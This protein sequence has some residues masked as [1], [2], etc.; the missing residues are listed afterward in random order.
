[1]G[2]SGDVAIALT[3]AGP[4]P[5]T[6]VDSSMQVSVTGV[7]IERPAW[8]VLQESTAASGQMVV[9]AFQSDPGVSTFNVK[10]TGLQT[11]ATYEVTSVDTGLLGRATGADLMAHGITVTQSPN[12]A[13]HILILTARP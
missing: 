2:P 11:Q 1:M 8:D 4:Q 3:S 6:V 9:S 12:S 7:P 10:P 13:A 5:T